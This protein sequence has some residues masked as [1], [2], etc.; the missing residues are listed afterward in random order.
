MARALSNG[1]GDSDI[2]RHYG[3]LASHRSVRGDKNA[4]G[5][6][7]STDPAER[8]HPSAQV[9]AGAGIAALSDAIGAAELALPAAEGLS[10]GLLPPPQARRRAAPSTPTTATVRIRFITSLPG[11]VA[12]RRRARD[13]FC[14]PGTY[15]S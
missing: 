5:V 10:A 2:A 7:L 15:I 13:E 4:D 1:R 8:T 14:E 11:V 9:A 6:G 3:A 12:R